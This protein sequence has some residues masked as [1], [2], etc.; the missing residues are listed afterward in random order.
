MG[1]PEPVVGISA[2]IMVGLQP[3]RH[4]KILPQRA[5]ILAQVQGVEVPDTFILVFIRAF[6]I[7][8]SVSTTQFMSQP[9]VQSARLNGE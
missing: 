6:Y 3:L 5:R 1:A 9:L 7:N 4:E 8:C 2:G